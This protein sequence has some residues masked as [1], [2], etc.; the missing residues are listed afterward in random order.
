MNPTAVAQHL[1]YF[2]IY[3]TH[4]RKIGVN[5]QLFGQFDFAR[6]TLPMSPPSIPAPSTW[7]KMRLGKLQ[8]FA[9]PARRIVK[10]LGKAVVEPLYDANAHLAWYNATRA[11]GQVGRMVK[12]ENCF[13][14]ASF[15]TSTC[16][17][18]LVPTHKIEKG[19]GV[20]IRLNH[21]KVY[22]IDSRGV[23][24]G[25]IEWR[26][27]F[28][29]RGSVSSETLVCR[30]FAVPVYKLHDDHA[31]DLRY[32]SAHPLTGAH[33]MIYETNVHE[34]ERAISITNQFET[35][36]PVAIVNQVYIAVPSRKISWK[37]VKRPA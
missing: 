23:P 5:I 7:P 27:Q 34:F 29:P 11:I 13:G 3:S 21:F 15:T 36:A 1:D 24:G 37:P 17:G 25:K 30:Y 2:A 19:S 26:D 33:L 28:H 12:V 10:R 31:P 14:H 8:Y 32:Q 22:K 35:E 4:E 18:L 6:P 9:N 20:S 16:V